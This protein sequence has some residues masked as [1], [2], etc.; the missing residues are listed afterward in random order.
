M[1][2]GNAD[3]VELFLNG[4]SL[5]KKDM[6]RNS[7]LRW[8]VP[9]EAGK[10]EAIAYKKGRKLEAKR[11]TTGDA[12]QLVV[13]PDKTTMPADG[14]DAAV[15]NVS[16]VDRQGRLVPDANNLVRFSLQGDAKIIG[17]GN[18]NPSSHEPD[19]YSGDNGWERKLFNGHCQVILQGGKTKGNIKFEAISANL[20]SGSTVL[21]TTGPGQ[22][23]LLAT[24]FEIPDL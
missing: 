11:E 17:V 19:K 18:G 15:V 21:R 6:V 1:P 3:N 12:Y 4:K 20:Q 23:N 10:L 9:F 5:G 22:A 8:N 7:H 14:E 13:T 16:V 2:G 24:A